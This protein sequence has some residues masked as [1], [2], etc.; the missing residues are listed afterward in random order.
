MK[1]ARSSLR[2]LAAAAFALT[3]GL[4]VLASAAPPQPGTPPTLDGTLRP[5]N[6]ASPIASGTTFDPSKMGASAIQTPS[7]VLTADVKPEGLPPVPWPA[8]AS[9]LPPGT[10]E[11]KSDP[12]A[13]LAAATGAQTAQSASGTTDPPGAWVG[14]KGVGLGVEAFS[15]TTGPSWPSC[16]TLETMAHLPGRGD[17]GWFPASTRIG[18][19]GSS[20][21]VEGVAFRLGGTCAAQYALKYNCHL[22]GLGD[23]T[24]MSAPAL[25]GTRGQGRPL[26]AFVVYITPSSAPQSQ[27]S[28]PGTSTVDFLVVQRDFAVAPDQWLGTTG[29]GLALS[30]LAVMPGPT[31]TT[32]PWPACLKMKYMGHVSGV[33]DTGWFD[34]PALLQGNLE[35]VAFK[36]DGTCAA[37]YVVEYQCHLQGIGDVASTTGP[38]FC[39]TRGQGRRLEAVRV[40]VRKK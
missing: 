1:A 30:S 32:R 35:G 15:V 40:T 16:L 18:T 12:M 26:E 11:L 22:K 34:A 25:C 23:Q 5:K 31:T 29:Q 39:G 4:T 28:T 20:S 13:A 38:A 33:G 27:S 10:I 19:P 7:Y 36:L 17:T 9:V 37:S 8:N 2:V 21:F 14:K 24:M 3:G 6:T